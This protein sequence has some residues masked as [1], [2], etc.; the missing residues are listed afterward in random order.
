MKKLYLSKEFA[1]GI[2]DALKELV[3]GGLTEVLP[4]LQKISVEG[5]KAPGTVQKNIG[6]FVAAR[7][8]SNHPITI[9]VWTKIYQMFQI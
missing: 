9:S 8:L 1:P 6:Q 2:T 4:C 3:G 5:L 7:Q